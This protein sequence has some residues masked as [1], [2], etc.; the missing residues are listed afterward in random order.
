MHRQR[1]FVEVGSF[2][3]VL[4]LKSTAFTGAGRAGDRNRAAS[5]S[6]AASAH[7]DMHHGKDSMGCKLILD[8]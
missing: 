2:A 1:K 7:A 4:T 6:G 3:K 8:I 5:I